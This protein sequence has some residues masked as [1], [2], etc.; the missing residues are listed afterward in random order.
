MKK[1]VLY[2]SRLVYEES[3][4]KLLP[5]EIEDFNEIYIIKPNDN[6]YKSISQEILLQCIEKD[7]V[8]ILLVRR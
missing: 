5:Q 2:I 7:L 1:K 8:C 3:G 4:L 6:I